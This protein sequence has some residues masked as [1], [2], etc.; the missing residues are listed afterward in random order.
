MKPSSPYS[1]VTS[2]LLKLLACTTVLLVTSL[3]F[4]LRAQ[5]EKSLAY[6]V[7]R[8]DTT[9]VTYLNKAKSLLDEIKR[10]K[11]AKTAP[12]PDKFAAYDVDAQD[13]FARE[14]GEDLGSGGYA[15]WRVDETYVAA[16]SAKR[17]F[18]DLLEFAAHGRSCM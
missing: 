8:L 15:E 11:E 7:I 18:V 12:S 3:P 13:Y 17:A 1:A 9:S 4:T 14:L 10:F 5:D 6:Y 2:K 16:L